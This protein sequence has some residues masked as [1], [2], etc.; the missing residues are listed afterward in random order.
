[1]RPPLVNFILYYKL[2]NSK[3]ISGVNQFKHWLELFQLSLD[4]VDN[5]VKKVEGIIHKLQKQKSK[6]LDSLP[7]MR[8][9]MSCTILVT[10][11][12]DLMIS[13]QVNTS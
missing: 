9:L 7:S 3:V 1:M 4:S 6:G 10:A 11:L 5:V 12:N 2:F 13:T 8:G